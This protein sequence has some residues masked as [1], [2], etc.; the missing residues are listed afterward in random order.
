MSA[1]PG[2]LSQIFADD[3]TVGEFIDAGPPRIVS[4]A[5]FLDFAAMTGDAH[6]LHYDEQYAAATRFGRPLAHGLLLMSFSALL[7]Q[8]GY[9]RSIITARGK[10]LCRSQRWRA[11]PFGQLSKV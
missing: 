6:P 4:L 8:I 1:G 10:S 3:L 5:K 11:A 9:N 2:T 7:F